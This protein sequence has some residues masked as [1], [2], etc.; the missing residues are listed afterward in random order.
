MEVHRESH[1]NHRIV[2]EQGTLGEQEFDACHEVRTDSR[3]SEAHKK[4]RYLQ[5]DD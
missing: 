4:C 5:D 1:H 3:G 2:S